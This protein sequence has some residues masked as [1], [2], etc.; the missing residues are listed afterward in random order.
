MSPLYS[1]SMCCRN[2]NNKLFGGMI[3]M[4]EVNASRLRFLTKNTPECLLYLL[5]LL[6]F[7]GLPSVIYLSSPVTIFSIP[8]AGVPIHDPSM[9]QILNGSLRRH[10]SWHIG[11][12]PH[13]K[14]YETDTLPTTP[15]VQKIGANDG[16]RTRVS[17][18]ALLG[19]SL[20]TTFAWFRR[21]DS[22][23]DRWLQRPP[24]Y[25]WTTPDQNWAGLPSW[26]A[27]RTL[28]PDASTPV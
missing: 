4:V 16:S 6:A 22:N 24:S 14:E 27:H 2:T 19:T 18:V 12:V 7:F 17:R 1:K 8:L 28:T 11:I 10:F 25:H 21:Y 20:C 13:S 23:V 9:F 5:I 3:Q 15:R 26:S